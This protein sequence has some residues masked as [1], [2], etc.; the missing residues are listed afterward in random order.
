V[1]GLLSRSEG[2]IGTLLR[3]TVK[4]NTSMFRHIFAWTRY[5]I[6]IAVIGAFLAAVVVTIYGALLVVNIVIETFSHDVFNITGAKHLALECIELV[7]LFLLGTV[8]YIISQGLYALFIDDRPSI[9]AWLEIFSLEDLKG[10]LIRVVIVLLAVTFLGAVVTWDGS[11][12]IID[13]GVAV[14]LV[15][16]ALG[17]LLRGFQPQHLLEIKKVEDPMTT[18]KTRTSSE[19]D[20]A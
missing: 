2:T 10:E 17:L 11:T 14:G 8:L 3:E 5:L 9:H 16:F 1:R 6:V 4:E 20:G 15:V 13:L 19:R 7:D 18:P 12:P